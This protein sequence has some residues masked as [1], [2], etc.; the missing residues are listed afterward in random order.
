M[1]QSNDRRGGI[2]VKYRLTGTVQN[3][4][5]RG[6]L[7]SAAERLSVRGWAKN[8]R[9]GSLIALLSGDESAVSEMVSRLRQGPTAADV[10]NMAE[11][12][13]EPDDVLPAGFEVRSF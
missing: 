3:V 12:M 6:Y 10:C 5:F 7:A 11:L 1:P 4:G 13:V 8:E 9:D 2:R